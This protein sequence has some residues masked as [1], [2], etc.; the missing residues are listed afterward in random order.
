M[1][2]TFHL[3]AGSS[4][5]IAQY[6]QLI[7]L[8]FE[9]IFPRT[10]DLQ[11]RLNTNTGCPLVYKG[12]KSIME[13]CTA[14]ARTLKEGIQQTGLFRIIS[15]DVGVPLVAFSLKD[16][17]KYTVFEISDRLR[18]FAWIVPAYT[19]PPDAQQVAVL[20]VVIRK[21]FSHSLAERLVTDIQKIVRELD[22]ILDGTKGNG[23]VI[24]TGLVKNN[25][26]SL[27]EE[28]ITKHCRRI[29][30]GRKTSGVC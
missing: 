13:N 3:C 26:M 20:R 10:I 7:R 2:S 28:E 30:D 9:V 29:M 6:Y 5:I 15:K 11:L 1:Y 14:C 22:T 21:D 12:Y 4:Q 25:G 18:K 19:M 17:T 24:G 16:S 8:G 27:T 23:H